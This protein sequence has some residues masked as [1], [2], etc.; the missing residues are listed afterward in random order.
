MTLKIQKCPLMTNLFV[1]FDK[2]I[3]TLLMY[4]RNTIQYCFHYLGNIVLF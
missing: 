3:K 2:I 4:C 1:C